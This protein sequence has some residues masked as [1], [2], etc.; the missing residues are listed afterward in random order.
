MTHLLMLTVTPTKAAPIIVGIF[1]AFNLGLIVLV[2]SYDTILRPSYQFITPLLA[3]SRA[4][5]DLETVSP[6]IHTDPKLREIS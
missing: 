1:L 3:G 6:Q 4:K 2:F 5:V